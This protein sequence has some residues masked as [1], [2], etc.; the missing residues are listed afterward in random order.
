MLDGK[1]HGIMRR[2]NFS[3]L[4]L[5]AIVALTGLTGFLLPGLPGCADAPSVPEDRDSYSVPTNPPVLENHASVYDPVRDRMVVFGGREGRDKTNATYYLDFAQGAWFRLDP[6]GDPPPPGWDPFA[7]YD[8][9]SDRLVVLVNSLKTVWSLS[10][11]GVPTWSHSEAQGEEP[12]RIRAVVYDP[13]RNRILVFE[14]NALW[15]LPLEG[16]AIWEPCAIEGTP[17]ETGT[18][19][20]A[21]FDSIRNRIILQGGIIPFPGYQTTVTSVIQMDD[22]PVW[23]RLPNGPPRYGHLGV[24]DPVEDRVLVFGGWYSCCDASPVTDT[25]Y[26]L[27]LGDSPVWSLVTMEESPKARGEFA[28]VFDSRRNRMVIHGG[29]VIYSDSWELSGVDP[30]VWNPIAVAGSTV[31]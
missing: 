31:E 20:L 13:N 25:T 29:G 21:V 6:K 17:Q 26:E 10:F 27:R 2:K 11:K 16:P 22:P 7:A 8:P 1:G 23:Q 18:H 12:P 15:K 30:L 9:E 14:N 5:R 3:T 4:G 28:A 19:S 24:F